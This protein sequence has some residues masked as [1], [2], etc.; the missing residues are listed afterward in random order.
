MII[1]MPDTSSSALAKR[2]VEIREEAGATAL[3]RVLTL[4]VA[5]DE[6]R[7]EAAIEAANRASFL[8]PCRIIALV[9]APGRK[10]RLD[11]QIRVGGD[12]GAAEVVVMRMEGPLA[13][14]GASAAIP[15]ILTDSP[16]VGWWPCNPPADTADDPVG[17]LCSRRITDSAAAKNQFAELKRR[18]AAYHPG[19]TDLAWTRLTRWRGV[20]AAALDQAPFDA[21]TG[22][23]V[24]GGGDSPS[25][26]LLAAWLAVR[27]DIPVT[28]ARTPDGSGLISVRLERESGNL[29]LVRPPGT[30]IATLT[31]PLQPVRRIPMLRRS[32]AECLAD[33][34]RH[35]D[36]DE[37]YHAT[38]TKGLSRLR[39]RTATASEMIRKGAA[40]SLEESRRLARRSRAKLTT[41][42]MVEAAGDEVVPTAKS[43][44]A[45]H[46]RAAEQKRIARRVAK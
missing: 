2:L 16:I 39:S 28:R 7:A 19:D 21:V 14:H 6:A 25:T 15:L 1:A 9:S 30:V 42:E 46:E 32:D 24:T 43:P 29:D 18:A 10:S 3:G 12:A 36:A 37:I 17:A 8:H 4:I 23:V 40:P 22:G 41:G 44:T 34:L 20:L 5:V 27:L 31:H 26:D 13:K 33:E 45:T 35:L 38:L 11:G